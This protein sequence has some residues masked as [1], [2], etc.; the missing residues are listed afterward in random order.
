MKNKKIR[1]FVNPKVIYHPPRKTRKK[2]WWYCFGGIV[3][4]SLFCIVLGWTYMAP[5]QEVLAQSKAG[6]DSFLKAQDSLLAQ[7]FSGA[8]ILLDA[9]INDFTSAQKTFKKFLWLQHAPWLGTQIKAI[10]NL[11]S[12]GIATG[13]SVHDVSAI[14]SSIVAPL[15]KDEEISLATLTEEQT[16][17]LLADI[18][19]SKPKLEEAKVSIDQAV[20]YVDKIPSHGLIRQISEV[21][22]P[23]KEQVPLLQSGLDQAISVSQI[24]PLIAGYPE[25]K[26]Y[27]FLLENNAE[28]APSGGF[29]GTYGILKIRDGDITSF[30][31][32]NVYNLDEPAEE[33]LDVDAPWQVARYNAAPKLFLRGASWSPDFPTTGELAQW[34]YREERGPEKNLDGTVAITPTFIQSLL[35]LTGEITVNGLTFTSENFTDQ[36]QDQVERGFLRQGLELSER[37]EIIG[38]LSKIILDDVLALPKSR[39]PELWEVFQQNI[40]EKQILLYANDEYVQ[41]MI[42]KENWGGAIEQVDHDY[43]SVIDANLASLKTDPVVRRTINYSVERDGENLIADVNITYEN[44]G[45]ITWKTTRYRTYTRVYVPEGSTLLK[46]EG[47]MVD[48]KMDDVGGVETLEEYQKT[49]FGAF[50]CIE[51]GESKTLH[52]KYHLPKRIYDQMSAGS[53]KL[54]IQK[55]AGAGNH[56]VSARIDLKQPPQQAAGLDIDTI[57]ADTVVSFSSILSQDRLVEITFD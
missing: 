20:S 7:D 3:M 36:L 6:K 5:A 39:W 12:V 41:S 8:Q 26:T 43:L 18:Y 11:F 40:K 54:L 23:L 15:T 35:G 51:P 45:T 55:Q 49:S 24:L 17:Q 34:F 31:T 52:Y 30:V 32:D 44:T 13:Q 2:V 53:Y 19:N 25:P 56:A 22:A 10:D 16:H 33:W 21:I 48:C 50:I 4:L 46:S 27:L 47:T 57:I 37:K 29:I 42:L 1:N 14:A 38:V 9:A 28:L